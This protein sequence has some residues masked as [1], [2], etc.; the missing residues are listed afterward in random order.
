MIK[1]KKV[2][3]N[4]YKSFLEK[5]EIDIEDGVT[6]IVGKNESGKTA[7]LEAISKFNYFDSRD[8]KFKFNAT[9][10]YPRGSLKK[11]EQDFPE[12]DFEVIKCTFE[13]SEELIEEIQKDIGKGVF[14]LKQIVISKKY[15]NCKSYLI[16]TDEKV[17]IKNFLSKYSIENEI[18]SALE[19]SE[20]IDSLINNLKGEEA[21]NNI[22]D[23]LVNNYIN[24]T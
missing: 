10:D 3:I 21:L 7:L 4:K 18:K 6:R 17:F 23:D 12:N 2:E 15:N 16:T 19:K 13:I 8:D 1:L 24:I 9:N 20:N 11:Y 5:Q 14:N 22:L